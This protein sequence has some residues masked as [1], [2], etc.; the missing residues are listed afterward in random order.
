MENVNDIKNSKEYSDFREY[1]EFRKFKAE[2]WKSARSKAQFTDDA[3]IQPQDKEIEDAVLGALMLERDAYAIVCD[4]LRPESFYDPGNQ[5]IYAAIN[6]LGVMQQ[7][8]DMLTVTQQLRADGALDDVGGP[9][10]ISELTSNVA[11]AAHI[12]YHARIVAQKFLA[13][14]LIS[15][16]SEIEKKSFDESYDIDDLLQEAEGKLFEISQGNLKKDFTQ[17]DPVINSAMEQIEAAGKRESGLSGL[18]TGFHNL[19]KLTSGWQNSDLIII[20]AR[21]AMGKTA[22]VL[23]MAKNMAVDYNTPV[24][25]F[26]LEMSN[27]QLVNRLISNVCEIEGEK[28]KSGRLSRQEWE[29][30]N[31]R[32]RSLFSAPLYVDDSPSLSILELRTK[33]R[34]LV[35]EHGV[36]IIIIDYLQLMNAT[37][38]KFGSREQEVSMISRSLKQLAKELNIPVI[39]LSQLSRKV[40][41]RNDGNK[42]PQLSDLRESGAIEQD[43]DIVCFIHRPEYYTRST[44]DAENRDIRGMAEFIVAKHR[45]GSVDD[46]EMTFV[47][48]FARFQNRS[49]PMPF[50]KGTM[51]SKINDDPGPQ[52]VYIPAP[53]D[54]Q[55]NA[56]DASAMGLGNDAQGGPMPDFLS[57]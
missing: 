20:A 41:E 12:E 25:I 40:E 10:R 29:Q 11:S 9:V 52:E 24:A 35:K 19:D 7:P 38:M 34:R 27:L 51:A 3:K 44:T 26:S 1:Q 13:R 43:A 21:P 50:E 30:L 49:E 57:E 53:A 23:S 16:C 42:R 39:A 15:F 18:Q 5:K 46:I 8:I 45:S 32:V 4:L 17:I 56:V 31:S 28:I 36:K 48:R 55:P 2:Q 47:A 37:G 14:R 33:A 6:K 54:G 22:F